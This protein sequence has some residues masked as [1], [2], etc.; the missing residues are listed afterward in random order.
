MPWS[1]YGPLESLALVGVSSNWGVGDEEKP[2]TGDDQGLPGRRRKVGRVAV[3]SRRAFLT[4]GTAAVGL[5]G[6]PALLRGRFLAGPTLAAAGTA[7]RTN[8]I[9]TPSVVQQYPL[10]CEAAALQAALAARGTAVTQDW[11]LS[12]IGADTRRAVT[13]VNGDVLDWGDPNE[14][15]VGDVMGSE[16]RATGYG[17]YQGP[18]AAAARAAGHSATGGQGWS[19]ADIYASLSDGYPAVIW[20]DASFTRVATRTWTAWNGRS[21][22]YTLGEHAVTLTGVDVENQTVQLLDVEYGRF[23]TFT[24]S[25]FTSF[26]SIFGNMAVVVG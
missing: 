24:M 1:D 15:F 22:P 2:D 6:A 20:T 23:R 5:S 16:L 26:W 14:S 13:D 18:I 10:D 19:A 25:D 12:T 17:V 4:I 7:V 21:I 9:S 3:L 8:H 11:I